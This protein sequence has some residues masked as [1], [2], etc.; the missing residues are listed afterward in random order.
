MAEE[1]SYDLYG[2]DED[3]VKRESDPRD[4]SRSPE[5]PDRF[6]PTGP[7]NGGPPFRPGGG[8]GMPP[9]GYTGPA[10]NPM[11]MGRGGPPG[12]GPM[13]P[14]MP[15]LPPGAIMNPAMLGMMNPMMMAAMM[16]AGGAGVGG[17]GG[18]PGGAGG[19][20]P[21]AGRG[22]TT[23]GGYYNPASQLKTDSPG[24]MF[25]GSL[26]PVGPGGVRS[27]GLFVGELQWYTSDADMHSVVSAAGLSHTYVSKETTFFEL[28]ANGKSRGVAYL[29]FS[30]PESVIKMK[31]FLDRNEIH[32]RVPEVK[33]VP[34]TQQGNPF[35]IIPKDP[36]EMRAEA[37]ARGENPSE[38]G[39]G[40]AMRRGGGAGG[41]QG[42]FQPY[43]RGGGG[44][45]GGR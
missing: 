19:P 3:Y 16:G 38:S 44:G 7:R 20:G 1:G 40:G 18:G 33:Y 8:P 34:G 4:R 21:G 37:L 2:D 30:D 36:K 5:R 15:P 22:S 28:K 39:S 6:A 31:E 26:S 29:E 24:P 11:F 42:R 32:G 45:G 10:F 14:G 13:G 27:K 17:M 23:G 43:G 25:R 35:R 9:G 12:M 41:G